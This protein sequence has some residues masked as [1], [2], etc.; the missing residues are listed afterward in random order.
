[1]TKLYV[2][3]KAVLAWEQ[4]KDGKPGYGVQYPNDGYVSWSPK[5]VFEAAYRESGRMTFG[6]ALQV[7]KD[8]KRVGRKWWNGGFIVIMPE[9]NLPPFSTQGTDRKVNDRTAKWIGEDKPL[10]CQPYIAAYTA[11]Q[12]WQPGWVA[13]QADMFAEDWGIVE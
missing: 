12:L 13:S 10:Y 7:L 4:D 2:G 8:G 3:T 11:E 5:D 9:L 1:M 6:Q